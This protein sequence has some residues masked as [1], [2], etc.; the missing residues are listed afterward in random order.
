L[1][2]RSVRLEPREKNVVELQ[3]RGSNWG[4][5]DDQSVV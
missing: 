3:W 5:H 2:K 4:S 1:E